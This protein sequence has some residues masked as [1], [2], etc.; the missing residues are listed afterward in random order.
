MGRSRS[1]PL[2]IRDCDAC[3]EAAKWQQMALRMQAQRAGAASAPAAKSSPDADAAK[4]S[5]GTS[6]LSKLEGTVAA[7]AVA[8]AAAVAVAFA[9]AVAVA[10]AAAVPGW[11]VPLVNGSRLVPGQGA[12]LSREREAP[13]LRR[14]GSG[15]PRTA[16]PGCCR[17]RRRRGRHAP[18]AARSGPMRHGRASRVHRAGT[19]PDA[20]LLPAALAARARGRRER[21]WRHGRASTGSGGAGGA[22][23]GRGDLSLSSTLV[24]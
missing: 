19:A 12:A 13:F 17:C 4:S 15:L 21:A 24:E 3:P 18:G 5:L 11:P 9:A 6:D 1:A 20:R 7:V 10:V 22:R 2:S 23:D 14:V 16:T 8:F